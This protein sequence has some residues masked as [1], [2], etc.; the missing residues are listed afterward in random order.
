MIRVILNI[1]MTRVVP[2]P[3]LASAMLLS[4]VMVRLVVYVDL[5]DSVD[6]TDTVVGVVYD[7]HDAHSYV[8]CVHYAIPVMVS[9]T[10]LMRMLMLMMICLVNV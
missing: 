10:F 5:Y 9:M 8:T 1:R 6:N 2:V 3:L 4:V 7:T